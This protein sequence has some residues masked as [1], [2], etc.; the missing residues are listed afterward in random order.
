MPE[1]SG[2]TLLELVIVTAIVGLLVGLFFSGMSTARSSFQN[3]GFQIERQQEARKALDRISSDLKM[4]SPYWQIDSNYYNISINIEG[5]QLDFY[6]P[7]FD[8]DN[9]IIILKAVRYYLG[10]LNSAQLLR[11]EGADFIVIA[12]NIDNQLAQKPFF[13]FNNTEHTVVDIKIPIIKNNA[14]FTLTSQLNLRNREVP[15]GEETIVE[16]I[17]D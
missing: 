2:Y 12:N 8:E 10:G 17:I 15:L 4:S 1:K 13:A 5:D 9:E 14:T 7:V 6:L 3:S 11:K 16:E